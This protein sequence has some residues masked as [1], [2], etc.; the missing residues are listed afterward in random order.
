MKCPKCRATMIKQ[1]EGEHKYA[2]VCPKCH[3]KICNKTK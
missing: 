2:Y 3:N 1:K